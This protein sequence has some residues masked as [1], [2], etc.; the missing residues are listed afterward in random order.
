M[1]E[2][3]KIKVSSFMANILEN[4]ALHFGFMKKGKTKKCLALP[5]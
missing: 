1:T 4:H 2:K 3:I 5:K